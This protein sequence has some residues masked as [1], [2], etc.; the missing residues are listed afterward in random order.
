LPAKHSLFCGIFD[1]VIVVWGLLCKRFAETD[2][3]DGKVLLTRADF[4]VG[5]RILTLMQLRTRVLPKHIDVDG[6]FISCQCV[7]SD[8]CCCDAVDCFCFVR[9]NSIVVGVCCVALCCAVKATLASLGD[10]PDDDDDDMSRGGPR[11]SSK[12]KSARY[13]HLAGV[14]CFWMRPSYVCWVLCGIQV[15]FIAIE[16]WWVC[17]WV[18]LFFAIWGSRSGRRLTLLDSY[19]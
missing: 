7:L 6:T 9:F 14:F 19:R 17:G 15:I 10:A 18:L 3:L 1:G 5:A 8:A 13:M 2:S 11:A 4:H 12:M 16:F